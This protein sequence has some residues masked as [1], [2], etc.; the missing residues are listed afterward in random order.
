MRI[1]PELFRAWIHAAIPDSLLP[2]LTDVELEY[3]AKRIAGNANHKIG[4]NIESVALQLEVIGDDPTAAE[5]YRLAC[6]DNARLVRYSIKGD[7]Q[8]DTPDWY[9]DWY[10]HMWEVYNNS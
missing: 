3:M 5:G 7:I 8:P 10:K 6:K 2:Q 1:S 9:K 4:E